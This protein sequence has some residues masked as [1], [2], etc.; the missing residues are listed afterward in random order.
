MRLID[1][2]RLSTR[3][4]KTNKLRTTL[5]IL[6]ISV[7]IGAILFLVSLGSGLQHILLDEIAISLLSMDIKVDA[8]ALIKL[9]K[10]RIKELE[11]IDGVTE[12]SPVFKV[13]SLMRA[14]ELSG[15]DVSVMLVRMS[16]PNLEGLKIEKGN[17]FVSDF[18]NK[19]IVS[20]ATLQ[21]LN[22]TID[23]AIGE[24]A[25]FELSMPKIDESGNVAIIEEVEIKKLDKTYEIAGV[26]D[27]SSEKY[28]YMAMDSVEN[29]KIPYYTQLKLAA[30]TQEDIPKIKI[31]IET[32]GFTP[33]ALSDTVKETDKIFQAIQI[34]LSVFGAVALIVS[35]IGMFNTMTIALLERTQEIGIMKALGASRQD[36]WKLF[37][38]ESVIIGFLGGAAGI[39][40]GFLGTLVVNAGVNA[41]ASN[42]GGQQ[43]N[44]FYISKNF[45]I[46]IIVFS[47]VVGFVTG[48]YP[49]RRASRLNPLEALRYK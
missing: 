14:N 25:N 47:T 1:I 5:T 26:I 33:T 32:I 29:L 21:L 28:V 48:L 40:L 11:A 41:L 23:N 30:R 39:I 43:V 36:I 49:S 13:R 24:K 19:I 4:F 37:L 18:D 31:Q 46:F 15:D 16:F 27:D 17:F 10:D 22:L 9:D 12:V 44:L 3:I 6:G 20:T 38:A 42:F 35:A 2:F 45:V 8:N 7:G 34:V